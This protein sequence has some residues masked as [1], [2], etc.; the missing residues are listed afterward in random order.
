[1]LPI[2]TRSRS[3]PSHSAFQLFT[4]SR[5]SADSV[6]AA[7]L[8]GGVAQV[9]A[10]RKFKVYCARSTRR[11]ARGGHLILA[12]LFRLGFLA[13]FLHKRFCGARQVIYRVR[14]LATFIRA[15]EIRG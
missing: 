12:S 7:I 8:R 1:L 2:F 6:T 5:C 4:I 3:R 9:A 10:P 13:N 14:S 15:A 11:I